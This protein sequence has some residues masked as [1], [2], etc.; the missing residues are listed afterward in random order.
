MVDEME[1]LDI[2]DVAPILGQQQLTII[3]QGKTIAKLYERIAELEAKPSRNGVTEEAY[4]NT[5]T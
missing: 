4:A 1:M 5:D 2:A 3:Q